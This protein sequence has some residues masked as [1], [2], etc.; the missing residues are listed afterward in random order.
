M[1]R[2]TS[3]TAKRLKNRLVIILI[4]GQKVV[5]TPENSGNSGCNEKMRVDG[6]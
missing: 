6:E 1:V 4:Y 5:G 3:K 2:R